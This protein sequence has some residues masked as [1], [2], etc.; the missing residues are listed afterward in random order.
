MIRLHADG[1]ISLPVE[2][3]LHIMASSRDIIH[4]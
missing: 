4:S 1:A 2:M 3:R